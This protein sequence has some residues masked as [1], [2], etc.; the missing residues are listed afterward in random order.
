MN[1]LRICS[2]VFLNS[3]FSKCTGTRN[4]H[5]YYAPV[6]RVLTK[7]Q[8]QAKN[9]EIPKRNRF[10]EWNRDAEIY[11]FNERLQEKFDLN[12]L[13]QAFIFKSYL[14]QEEK[15]QKQLLPDQTLN[16][17]DN[18][19]LQTKG[20]TVTSKAVYNYLTESLM[21]TP[22]EGIRAFHDY[23]LSGNILANASLHIGTKD[24]ILSK[25]HPVETETLAN[26]FLAIVGALAQST[27]DE[28]AALFVRDFLI[29][30]LAEKDLLEIWSPPASLAMLNSILS[31]QGKD[32][33]EPR[34]ISQTGVNTLVPSYHIG[35]YSNKQF[36]GSGF[37]QTIEEAENIACTNALCRIF[38]LLDSGQPL[39]FNKKIDMS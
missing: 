13:N 31:T 20:H 28:H 33:A 38:G 12:L 18:E 27:N 19:D 14:D 11:A 16:L 17:K 10:I 21:C 37:G 25:D 4:L 26:T 15:E 5:R 22:E 9:K 2:S 39:R 30:C 34:I 35:L 29:T 24:I 32:V 6:Q 23:L 7:R 8:A 36:I 3:Q 1:S